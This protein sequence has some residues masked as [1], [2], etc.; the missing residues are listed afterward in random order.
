MVL[1]EVASVPAFTI[2]IVKVVDVAVEVHNNESVDEPV[3]DEEPSNSITPVGVNELTSAANGSTGSV[4]EP[5]TLTARVYKCSIVD[6]DEEARKVKSHLSPT[7]CPA[8]TL[9]AI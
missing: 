1:S 6:K 2:V 4:A 7:V 9:K 3:K 5:T 8:I